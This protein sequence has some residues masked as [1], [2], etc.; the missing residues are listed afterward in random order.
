MGGPRILVIGH[1]LIGRQR[2][3][4]VAA[5]PRATLAGTV[6]P[7]ASGRDDAP[8]FT[9]LDEVPVRTYDAAVI[10]L[11]TTSPR[12]PPTRSWPPGARC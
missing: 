4:A 3:S 7:L 12:S 5:H 1:G 11:P 6:D 2:A 9:V 10:A 8:H